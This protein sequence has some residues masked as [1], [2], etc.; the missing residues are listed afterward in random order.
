MLIFA[1]FDV[2]LTFSFVAVAF[3]LLHFVPHLLPLPSPPSFLHLSSSSS[4]LT[5][6][7][8]WS[9]HRAVSPPSSSQDST[10]EGGWDS[11]KP[12]PLD[13]PMWSMRVVKKRTLTDSSQKR[14]NF[15]VYSHL[16][17]WDITAVERSI[18]SL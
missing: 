8:W 1:R 7:S 15:Y 3:M 5:Q 18:S 2:T 13:S 6:G 4:S 17:P 14:T 11:P 12:H 10:G 9:T 16:P